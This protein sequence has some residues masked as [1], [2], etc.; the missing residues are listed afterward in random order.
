MGQIHLER[1]SCWRTWGSPGPGSPGR[2]YYYSITSLRVWI[3]FILI[4]S[5]SFTFNLLVFSP[6][7]LEVVGKILGNK[8]RKM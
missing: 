7:V 2:N 5:N 6:G 4:L 1:Q 8:A 3:Y